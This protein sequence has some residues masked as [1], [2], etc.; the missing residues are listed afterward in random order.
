MIYL[1]ISGLPFIFYI[2]ASYM[3]YAIQFVHTF[4]HI[5]AVIQS[6]GGVAN[7]HRR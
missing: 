4:E 7:V 5:V 1:Y 3:I 6:L 2:P